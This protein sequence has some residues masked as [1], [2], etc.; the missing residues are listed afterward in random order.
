MENQR[1][2][3]ETVNETHVANKCDNSSFLVLCRN[4]VTTEPAAINQAASTHP[5]PLILTVVSKSVRLSFYETL[6]T[7]YDKGDYKGDARVI[8]KYERKVN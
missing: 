6:A 4:D 8:E 3:Q 7:H 2:T 5:D 1:I